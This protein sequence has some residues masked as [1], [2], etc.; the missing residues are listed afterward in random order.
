ML[1]LP[2]T[3]LIGPG[4]PE[5]AFAFDVPNLFNQAPE[6][7]AVPTKKID[8]NRSIDTI[9]FMQELA[10][11]QDELLVSMIKIFGS[12]EVGQSGDG[13]PAWTTVQE[14]VQRDYDNIVA[15]C[16]AGLNKLLEDYPVE[17]EEDA[18]TSATGGRGPNL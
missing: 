4:I 6:T 5:E 11:K 3:M 2:I 15:F 8:L 12:I 18:D 7:D 16:Q 10:S 9:T 1:M 14:S 13:S 17:G